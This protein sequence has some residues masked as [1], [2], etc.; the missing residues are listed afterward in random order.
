[1]KTQSFVVVLLGLFASSAAH[2]DVIK[3][4]L[5][6]SMTATS[7]NTADA[8]CREWT[9]A[10]IQ[11]GD[12]KPTVDVGRLALQMAAN[13][14]ASHSGAHTFMPNSHVCN[15]GPLGNGP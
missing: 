12:G 4:N 2:A 1:M 6:Y 13:A 3:D 11:F 7:S 14:A 5:D 9:A 10:P 15:R 8:N